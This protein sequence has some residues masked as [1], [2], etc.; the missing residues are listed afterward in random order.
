MG[1]GL[2]RPHLRWSL[3]GSRRLAWLVLRRRLA[4]VVPVAL[5]VPRLLRTKARCLAWLALRCGL[6]GILPL[7]LLVTRLFLTKARCLAQLT[8]RWRLAHA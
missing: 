7:A 5:L 6:A 2:L 4:G 3:V 1:W 8:L